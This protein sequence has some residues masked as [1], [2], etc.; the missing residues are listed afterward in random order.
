[1]L[2]DG[3]RHRLLTHAFE[4]L[5]HLPYVLRGLEGLRIHC[6]VGGVAFYRIGVVVLAEDQRR[7]GVVQ[8]DEIELAR[9]RVGKRV[10]P[11]LVLLTGVIGSCDCADESSWCAVTQRGRPL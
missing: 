10:Q 8:R 9:S 6:A 4:L 7:E 1:M 3:N 11:A 5:L 2:R